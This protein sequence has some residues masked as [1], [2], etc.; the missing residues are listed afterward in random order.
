MHCLGI[1]CLTHAIFDNWIWVWRGER[2][3]HYLQEGRHSKSLWTNSPS[4]PPHKDLFICP[5]EWQGQPSISPLH[6]HLLYYKPFLIKEGPQSFIWQV[7]VFHLPPFPSLLVSTPPPPFPYHT[8][9]TIKSLYHLR[10]V[11]TPPTHTDANAHTSPQLLRCP[12]S[13]PR[14]PPSHWATMS[15][16][17][18]TP[19]HQS[20]S[21]G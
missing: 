4:T 18:L 13:F 14:T 2:Q 16:I 11:W 3:F 6:Q 15:Y 20:A 12:R 1:F 9:V 17:T 7:W 21:I 10:P 19:A 8:V 5:L